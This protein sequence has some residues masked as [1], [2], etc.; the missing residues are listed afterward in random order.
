MTMIFQVLARHHKTIVGVLAATALYAVLG[1]FAAPWLIKKLATD[2]VA[3]NLGATLEMK[4]VAV[5][6]FT[7]SLRIDSLRLDAPDGNLFLRFDKFLVNFQASSLFRWAWTFREFHLDG[8]E[9]FIHR[10]GEGTLNTEFLA[11]PAVEPRNPPNSEEGGPPRLLVQDFAIRGSVV[12]W[13]DD[14]PPEPVATEFGPVNVVIAELNTLPDRGGSQ[15]VVI[16]TET[17]GTL[18]WTGS[19]HLNPLRSEG[20]ASVRGSH[21]PLTSA[22]LKHEIGFDIVDGVADVDFQYRV[23]MLESGMVEVSVDD[24]NLGF[25]DIVVRTFNEAVGRGGDDREVLRLSRIDLSGGELRWP[26]RTASAALLLIDRADV[27]LY[28]DTAGALNIL[29]PVAAEP[30]ATRAQP[31][32]DVGDPWQLSLEQLDVQ[33]L[34]LGLLDD[35]VTPSADVGWAALNAKI[36]ALSNA[37]GASFPTSVELMGRDGG[38]IAAE[39][40]I[41]VLPNPVVDFDVAINA[42]PLGSA[43]PYLKPLAD[44]NLDSGVLNVSVNLHSSPADA[45]RVAGDLE[46]ADFVITETD[47]GSRLGSWKS[48]EAA[49]IAYTAAGNSLE[50]S[51]VRLKAPYGDILIAADGSINL[52]RVQKGDVL[53][54]E[55]TVEKSVENDTAVS[56]PSPMAVTIGRILITDA[57]ADFAD[58]SLPL[59]FSAQIAQLNGEVSTISTTSAEP[60]AIKLEGKVDEFGLVRVGGAITPLNP[61]AN[62]DIQVAFQNVDM[63]KFS[64]YSIPF[65]GREIANGRLDLDLGYKLKEGKLAGENNIVLRNFELGD[66]VDH[67]DAMNLPLGLAVALLKD[68]EGKIDIDLPVEGD[69]NDPK[70]RLGGVVLR[71]LGNLI[72]RIVTSPFTLLA[73]LVGAEADEL[74]VIV[75]DPGRSDLSPPEL[76]KAMKIAEALTL[77]PELALQV[78]GGYSAEADSGAL[79]TAALDGIVAARIAELGKETMYAEAR[80]AVMEAL[81][82]ESM[83]TDAA[84]QLAEL[85][86]AHTTP[87][88]GEGLASFDALAYTEALRRQLI[89]MQPIEDAELIALARQRGNNV[90]QAILGAKPETAA[91]VVVDATAEAVA[92]K[93]EVVP[94][95]V[96]LTISKD[97]GNEPDSPA[98]AL[99]FH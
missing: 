48:L 38:S 92:L 19:L 72:T 34:A 68:P 42:V 55:D 62:T 4:R 25:S 97:L 1:F 46:I 33:N 14:V 83:A 75:F 12:H 20:S 82:T 6:P 49:S 76:E 26:S 7:L 3:E 9:A 28:R 23:E 54:V 37:P 67:P 71:A 50:V 30:D 88:A 70:F 89:E 79:R 87:Q 45:L 84:D 2:Y 17:Q 94:M 64:A 40:S 15:E 77:R 60:S 78:G 85:K 53:P 22:Y 86:S 93:D 61:P 18:S 52:G 13:R 59:P 73:N 69:L 65:A 43:Q 32:G 47:E 66:D 11:Q 39:G 63:P 21:F 58:L 27:S 41:S 74:E 24:F 51:E 5:N 8:L 35:S 96:R 95:R 80:Q 31:G 56:A 29:P 36:Q 90:K 44:L 81:F 99:R 98:T 57:A 10:D 91:R 16:T